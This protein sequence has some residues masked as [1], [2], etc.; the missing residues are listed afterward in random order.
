MEDWE[1]GSLWVF[2]RKLYLGVQIQLVG[3]A[4]GWHGGIDELHVDGARS[5]SREVHGD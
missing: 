5:E 3:G 2:Q 4:R 1:R